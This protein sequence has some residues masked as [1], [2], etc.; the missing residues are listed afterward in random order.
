MGFIGGAQQSEFVN[1]IRG[2]QPDRLLAVPIDVGKRTAMAMVCDFFGEVVAPPFTFAM[3]EGG[4][5]KLRVEVSRAEALR[6][7]LVVKVGLEQAGHYHRNLMARL[8]D[9][10]MEV[11]LLN[12]VQVKQNRDQNLL[13]TTK[14]D[15][16]DLC[17]IAELIIRGKGRVFQET[18]TAMSIQTAY[19]AHRR[20]KVKARSALKN[21]IHATADLVFPLLSSC[22]DDLLATK[23]G[24]LI[25]EEGLDPLRVRQLGEVKLRTYAGNRGVRVTRNKSKQVVDAAKAALVLD[26]QVSQAY[27]QILRTDAALLA[28]LDQEIQTSE[29]ALAEV[30]PATPANILTTLPHV[31]VVRASNYGAGIGDHLRFRDASQVYR[32]S[33]LVP[34]T[35][36][37]AGRTRLGGSISREGKVELREAILDIGM[38][39]RR[40]HPD[41][42]RYANELFARGKKKGHVACALGHRANRVAFAMM[43]DQLPFDSKMWSGADGRVIAEQT[44]RS[45]LPVR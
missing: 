4:V 26:G 5:A 35:Y 32:A 29:E 45:T 2:K 34:S 15:E 25:I 41:F 14:T 43:R 3:N 27:Q 21:Q 10:G 6:D 13:R 8:V 18:E 17:A 40:G 12:P 19:T 7:A 38:A 37:S 22:F 9:L 39:L 31:A 33:G 1:K 24:R 20:R 28:R 23:F 16:R 44:T 30:L 11:T 36:E 42:A